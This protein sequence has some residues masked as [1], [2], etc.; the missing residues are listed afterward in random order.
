[1]RRVV[2]CCAVTIAS[3]DDGTFAPEVLV[4]LTAE[5]RSR[6]ELIWADGKYHNHS[7]DAWLKRTGVDYV[8]DVVSRPA[9]SKGFVLLHRRWVVE[10]TLARIGR[11]RRNSRDYEWSTESSEAMIKNCSIHR[12]LRVLSPDVLGRQAPFKY[13]ESQGI[14]PG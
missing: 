12:M 14:I 1:L 2:S 4:G 3:A 10:R 13:R 11:Y 8:I 7:L 5:H 9:G 6:L